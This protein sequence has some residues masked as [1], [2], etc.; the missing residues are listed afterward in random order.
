M[1]GVFQY[2]LGLF[3]KGKF[4]NINYLYEAMVNGKLSFFIWLT[5]QVIVLFVPHILVSLV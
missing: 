5:A 1:T 3:K 2:N 4:G